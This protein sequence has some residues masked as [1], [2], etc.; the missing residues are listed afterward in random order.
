MQIK[1]DI[2]IFFY[3]AVN[4]QEIISILVD[5]AEASWTMKGLADRSDCERLKESESSS[6]VNALR[7]LKVNRE[8]KMHSEPDAAHRSDDGL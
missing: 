6:L 5:T 4:S 8:M 2:Y 7:T 1:Q 3:I